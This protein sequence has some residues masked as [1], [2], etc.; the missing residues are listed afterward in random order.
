MNKEYGN[1]DEARKAF[2]G[3][4]E[5]VVCAKVSPVLS[6]AVKRI[7]EENERYQTINDLVEEAVID[8]VIAIERITEK[9]EGS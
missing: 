7:V 8:K 3:R 6:E 5:K 4:R 1:N 2:V 9:Q